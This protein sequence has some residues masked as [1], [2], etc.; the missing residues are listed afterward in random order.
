MKS[1]KI[2]IPIPTYGFDPTEV[3]IPWKIL[4]ENRYEVLFATPRGSVRNGKRVSADTIMLTGKGLGIWKSI[5]AAREDAVVAYN[6][7]EN[8]ETFNNP[9]KYVDVR[10]KDFDG[11]IL[12]GGH[13]KGVREYLESPELQNL[14]GDFFKARKPVGA[15]CHGVLLVARSK[16]PETGKSV[17]YDY[18]TTSLLRSQE[19]LAY[20]LTR[21]WLKDYYLTYPGTTVEDEVKS[22]L[23]EKRNFIKGPIP[24][25]R[26]SEQNL[27]RG[28][29]L[30]DRNYLSS[31][32]PGDVYNFVYSFMEMVGELGRLQWGRKC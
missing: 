17:I 8:S 20:Y 21:L 26:D 7:M 32:W 28:F 1:V 27:N 2:L 29:A 23:G 9:F 14:I 30:R 5:L 19:L 22:F 18:R 13:D 25:S 3:A 10:E 16:N 12:P 15:I 11:I 24:L 6:E 4:T 31:R